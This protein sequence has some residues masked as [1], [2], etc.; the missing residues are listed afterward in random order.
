MAKRPPKN[1]KINPPEFLHQPIPWTEQP[2]EQPSLLT[3]TFKNLEDSIG[4]KVNA[5]NK[6]TTTAKATLIP[7]W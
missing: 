6:D 4:V 2:M 1:P 3:S 7:N 5:M